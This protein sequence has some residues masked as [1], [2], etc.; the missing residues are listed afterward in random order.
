MN[1][2]N[3]TPPSPQ[4]PIWKARLALTGGVIA[5]TLSPLFFR[6]ANAPGITT[7]F[8][9]MFFTSIILTPLF[10]ISIRT[11]G[12]TARGLWIWPILGG[13][14]SSLDHS[15]WSAGI[16][17]TTVANATLLNNVS[18]LW[19]ALIAL[20]VFKEDFLKSF[21]AGLVMV[22]AGASLVLGSTLWVRPSF[23]AGDLL[24]LGS[25][26]F[27][28]LFFLATQK[29]RTFLDTSRYLWA[30]TV[31][32][33]LSLLVI[34]RIFGIPLWGFNTQTYLVF[35]AAAVISQFGAYFLITYSLG[36]LPASVVTPS[37]VAQ[38]VLTALLAIPITG[39]KLLPL[40]TAGG[41]VTLLG[42]YLINISKQNPAEDKSSI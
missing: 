1:M 24:A 25:S 26:V 4:E 27:Y 41:I 40:Q 10:V 2:I 13:L 38:P 18:P 3:E 21:W 31:T 20:L 33:C 14:A 29:G 19:V 22:L 16:G 36:R 30:M 28:A 8:Y 34:S 32:A 6:W 39:E 11:K 12:K 9:R 23:A 35:L 15:L 17:R 37:M 5:L 42:I 7:S